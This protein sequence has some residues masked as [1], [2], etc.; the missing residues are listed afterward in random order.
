MLVKIFGDN[1]LQNQTWRTRFAHSVCQ[2]MSGG[3]DGGPDA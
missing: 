3:V 2:V 1:M